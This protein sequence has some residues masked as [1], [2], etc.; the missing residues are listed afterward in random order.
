MAINEIRLTYSE[1]LALRRKDHSELFYSQSLD[2]YRLTLSKG[3]LL[4]YCEI[5]SGSDEYTDF[6]TYRKVYC[7]KPVI[8]NVIQYNTHDLTTASTFTF[9]GTNLYVMQPSALCLLQMKKVQLLCH[10][11]T[12]FDTSQTFKMVLWE[13]LYGACPA[14]NF[15]TPAPTAYG[16]HGVNGWL[17]IRPTAQEGPQE[18]E[19]FVQFEKTW[20]IPLVKATVFTYQSVRQVMTKT[21]PHIYGSL[22]S[23][24]F[25]YERDGIKYVRLR[26]SLNERMEMYTSDQA[27]IPPTASDPQPATVAVMWDSYDEW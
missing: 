5:N 14:F 12:V 16:P 21:E 23:L 3:S 20:T 24:E 11:D 17:K 10:K 25:Q 6:E 19:V 4:F 9:D 18:F 27:L 26:S 8:P 15:G 1:I 7:N 2:S 22:A 13:G